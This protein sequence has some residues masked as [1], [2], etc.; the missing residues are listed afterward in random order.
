MLKPDYHPRHGIADLEDTDIGV[1]ART[2]LPDPSRET[3][4]I[5]AYIG[6]RFSRSNKSL[7]ELAEETEV[8]GNA[9]GRLE[10]IFEGYGHRSVGD[11]ARLM[12]TLEGIPDLEAMYILYLLPSY[13]AQ[14]R[15]TRYQ[16]FSNPSFVYP[17]LDLASQESFEEVMQ[18]SFRRYRTAYEELCELYR[19]LYPDAKDKTIEARALD[20]ARNFL[21]AGA[22]TNVAIYASARAFSE[23]IAQLRG[24]SF[25]LRRRCGKLL[26]HLLK[27]TYHNKESG[28]KKKLRDFFSPSS[29]Y[30]PEAQ[31]LIRHA[32][33]KG[34]YEGV[35]TA[36]QAYSSVATEDWDDNTQLPLAVNHTLEGVSP[37]VSEIFNRIISLTKGFNRCNFKPD[38]DD[39]EFV[40]R[41]LLE[42]NDKV[43]L[44]NIAQMGAIR[45]DGVADLGILRDI[46][47]HRSTERFFPILETT[48]DF[49][50]S[51]DFFGFFSLAPTPVDLS[52]E[53]GLRRQ[54][55]SRLASAI[56][57][58]RTW[59]SKVEWGFVRQG[60]ERNNPTIDG[61]AKHLLPLGSSVRY[62]VS[63][64]PDDLRYISHLRTKPGGHYGYR[65]LLYE[66][67]KELAKQDSFYRPLCDSLPEIHE[68]D[69]FQR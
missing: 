15:S 68:H 19:N 25:S 1:T 10:K 27:G 47:R 14:Q 65:R 12:V 57:D 62:F 6:A 5:Q 32:E 30:C 54:F 38:S 66:W 26:F 51:F 37:T 17:E 58:C 53:E 20:K 64:S 7:V 3:A 2:L 24:S 59:H 18:T 39:I 50:E 41:Q 46:N 48:C 52:E 67:V 34:K 61:Y 11:Q 9:S 35:M 69:F 29:S 21:P 60:A 56:G 28:I 33:P 13:A 22:R 45:F 4:S 49:Q 8:K 63:C 36:L 44:G 23:L 55:N 16:D 31:K 42:H 43:Y 40:S